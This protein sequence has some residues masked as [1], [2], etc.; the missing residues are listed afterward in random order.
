MPRTHR[1]LW[2]LTACLAI[3]PLALHTE[4]AS[5]TG[6]Q[7]SSTVLDHELVQ[8]FHSAPDGCATFI[9]RLV[10]QADL[11]E[12]PVAPLALRR[13]TTARLLQQHALRT[14]APLYD[15]LNHLKH[16]GL[17]TTYTPYWIF[18]GLAV[19]GQQ[20]AAETLARHPAVAS[21]RENRIFVLDPV[22]SITGQLDT[23]T[24]PWGIAKIRAPEVWR[25]FGVRGEGIVVA[26]IDTG[27]DWTHPALHSSYRGWDP[28]APQHDYHWMDVTPTGAPAQEPNDFNN[29]GTHTMGTMVGSD[30]ARD[31]IVGVAPAARW[32]AVK[33]FYLDGVT[34][35]SDEATL[36]SAF[37]WCLAPTDRNGQNADP[38]LA[39]DIIN[40]S[41]GDKNGALEVFRDDVRALRAAGILAVFSAG[42]DGPGD[43]TV[44]SPASYPEAFAVGATTSTDGIAAFSSRGPSP[45]DGG[46]KPNVSAPGASIYSTISGGSYGYNSGTSMAAPHVSGLAALLWSADRA[47]HATGPLDGQAAN[48]TLTVT[49]TE[50]L[51]VGT[52]IDL[53]EP[54]PDNT[55]GWGRINALAAMQKLVG[56][57]TLTGVVQ[58]ASSGQRIEL[59]QLTLQATTHDL[60]TETVTNAAGAFRIAAPPG[61]YT[62]TVAHPAHLTRVVPQVCIERDI[63][64]SLTITLDHP[65]LQGYV[66]HGDPAEPVPT[67]V[68]RLAGT[69][70]STTVDATGHY[71]FAVSPGAYA[72]EVLPGQPGLRGARKSVTISASTITHTLDIA[73]SEAPRVLVV[74]A[75]AWAGDDRAP[76]Y[77]DA[78][79][80]ALWGYAEHHIATS[81]DDIPELS[82]LA[83]YDAVV[84]SHPS[85]APS[86]IGAWD[87]LDAYLSGGG[88]LLVSGQNVAPMDDRYPV[89]PISRLFHARV[90]S[91]V[92]GDVIAGTVPGPLAGLTA[93]PNHPESA[94][95]Q[96]SL[97]SLQPADGWGRPLA[98]V[99]LGA[100]VAIGCRL[101]ASAA[102]L[103]SFGLESVGPTDARAAYLSELLEW[104][105]APT[106]HHRIQLLLV[107][108]AITPS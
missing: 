39:P 88:R 87:T 67:A 86:A 94:G 18:N 97:T 34:W 73:L 41:W 69:S 48:P 7:P 1:F 92:L 36:H 37:Q 77:R 82:L 5:P 42:N 90:G 61:V 96:A 85:L 19:H 63:T 93:T 66:T 8:A 20:E 44:G 55:F 59:A 52:A 9:V 71:T 72:V 43:A 49:T 50:Q 46:L 45:V 80:A 10:D 25:N 27:V 23:T 91:L 107:A 38:S 22:P 57:G 62:L 32:V 29:H 103:L 33:A 84:W 12:I 31:I 104:L 65:V 81:P 89:S 78:L 2:V 106:A 99:S 14:Q 64:T 75:D 100:N 70:L 15:L 74:H 54:G 98:R 102:V 79:D 60:I 26:N 76:Y 51:I 30:P 56:A 4:A 95:N 35:I 105:L 11:A 21:V 47:Y 83:D 24:I 101:P 28:A 6:I 17:I 16:R 3:T 58:S 68:V 13:A 53:G 108:R 40:N